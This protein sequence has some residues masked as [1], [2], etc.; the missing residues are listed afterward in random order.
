MV[1]VVEPGRVTASGVGRIARLTAEALERARHRPAAAA[2]ELLLA[3]PGPR[4]PWV[5]TLPWIP[6]PAVGAEPGATVRWYRH[7]DRWLDAH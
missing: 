3:G 2:M 5:P 7:V 1:V 4:P 6:L